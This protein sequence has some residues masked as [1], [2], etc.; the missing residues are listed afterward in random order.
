MVLRV[1]LSISISFK[2]NRSTDST[3]LKLTTRNN[4]VYRQK[5]LRETRESNFFRTGQLGA[6]L[7]QIPYFENKLIILETQN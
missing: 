1:L 2:G 6:I 3:I 5:H 7:Q 4:C